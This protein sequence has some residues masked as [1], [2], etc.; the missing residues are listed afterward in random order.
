MKA[1]FDTQL[2]APPFQVAAHHTSRYKK[3]SNYFVQYIDENPDVCSA[4]KSWIC[5][6]NCKPSVTPKD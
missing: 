1:A 2:T 6:Q 4:V 3:L 5:K